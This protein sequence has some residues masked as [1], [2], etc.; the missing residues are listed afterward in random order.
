MEQTIEGFRRIYVWEAPVRIFHWLN[1]LSIIALAGTG[2]IIANPPAIMSGTEATNQYW[3]GITRFVHFVA[4]YVFI[5]GLTMRVIW[6]FL[7]NKYASWKVF[8]PYTRKGLHNLIHVLKMDVLL[9]KPKKFDC[10]CQ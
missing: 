6:S 8:F 4:A 3:F 7:G 1:V 10:T 9:G 5:I 2:I